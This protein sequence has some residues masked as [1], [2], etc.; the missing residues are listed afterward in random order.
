MRCAIL[1]LRKFQVG[2]EHTC[3]FIYIILVPFRS[4]FYYENIVTVVLNIALKQIVFMNATMNE[5]L[6]LSNHVHYDWIENKAQALRPFLIV[7]L[8][9]L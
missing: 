4:F 3:I 2:A 5:K 9:P 8:Y 1:S 6:C 7:Y